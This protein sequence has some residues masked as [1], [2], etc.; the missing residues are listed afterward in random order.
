MNSPA[1][2]SREASHNAQAGC[3]SGF[4]IAA[5]LVAGLLPACVGAVGCGPRETYPV[6]G[7]VV[8]ADTQ[9]PA[10]ELADYIV[11][12]DSVERRVGGSSP[13][14]GNGGFVLSTLRPGDGAILGRHRVAITPPPRDDGLPADWLIDRRYGDLKTSGLEVEVG[15]APNTLTITVDRHRGKPAK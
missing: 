4:A 6:R 1:N 15:Q 14:D 13:I 8:F 3:R 9:Q 10:R 11:T 7:V 2:P 12:F 5:W